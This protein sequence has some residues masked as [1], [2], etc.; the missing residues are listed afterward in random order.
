MYW[1][2]GIFWSFVSSLCPSLPGTQPPRDIHD[3]PVWVSPGVAVEPSNSLYLHKEHVSLQGTGETCTDSF[4][5]LRF[6]SFDFS[7]KA[8]KT[9]VAPQPLLNVGIQVEG[10][11]LCPW[12]L[13]CGLAGNITVSL[14]KYY[15]CLPGND[16]PIK[17]FVLL[18]IRSN[19]CVKWLIENVFWSWGNLKIFLLSLFFRFHRV[20]VQ[21]NW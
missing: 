10:G 16:I 2:V 12:T 7:S 20:T 19:I 11:C 4:C 9:F 13:E 17:T 18:P 15:L 14:E 21:S 8:S 6:C 5:P 3:F 1:C